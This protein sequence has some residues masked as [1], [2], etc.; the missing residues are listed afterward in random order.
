[1]KNP[2]CLSLIL[3][4]GLSLAACEEMPGSPSDAPTV[5]A[6]ATPGV[7]A[8]N[9]EEVMTQLAGAE[10]KTWKL[11]SRLEKGLR[12]DVAN[13]CHRDDMLKLH[14]D[15]R[16]EFDNGSDY[17]FNEDNQV[18]RSQSGIWQLTDKPSLLII[19][20]EQPP[21]ELRVEKLDAQN[22][23]LSFQDGEVLVEEKYVAISTDLAP[24]ASSSAVVLQP[25]A[26][27]QP[28]PNTFEF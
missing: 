23:S 2:I 24:A 17:C 18:I 12:V 13:S 11:V 16:V 14:R 20:R 1:M 9:V 22:L 7:T 27:K 10:S 15:R 6:S 5:A 8:A 25:S 28:D 26:S 3:L 19:L 21:Y 4:M